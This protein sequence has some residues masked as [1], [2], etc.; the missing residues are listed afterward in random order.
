M[1]A[2]IIAASLTAYHDTGFVDVAFI[3]SDDAFCISV[4]VCHLI[5]SDGAIG[6]VA[7]RLKFILF[8]L[9]PCIFDASGVIDALAI[10]AIDIAIL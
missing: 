5:A 7:S 8:A 2:R 3:D 9:F 6:I 1:F 4:F 10:F